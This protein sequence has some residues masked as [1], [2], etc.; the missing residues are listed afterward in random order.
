MSDTAFVQGNRIPNRAEFKTPDGDLIDPAAVYFRIKLPDETEATFKYG[1]DDEV[2]RES[3]GVYLFRHAT[4]AGGTYLR[5]WVAF[6][7][8]GNETAN[9]LALDVEASGFT[10]PDPTS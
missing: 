5:R 6:D 4:P 9:E 2:E 1:V 3:E 7:S 10:S 8:D